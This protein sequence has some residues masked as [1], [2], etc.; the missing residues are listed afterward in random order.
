[1]SVTGA[2]TRN[3]YVASSGQTVFPYT[4]QALSGSDVTVIVNGV[5][6]EFNSQYT[7]SNV[8]LAG[9]GNVI[10]TTG[11]SSGETVSV[12]L[13][14][15]ISRTTNYQNAG[16][17][18]AS[19]VNGDFDKA[20]V[21]LNQV[22]TSIDR[23]IGLK[24]NDPTVELE[25]PLAAERAN[26]FLLFDANGN[27]GFTAVDPGPQITTDQVEY[28]NSA[29]GAVTRTVTDKLKE[30]ISVKDFGAVGDGVTDDTTA[31]Q[32]AIDYAE[33]LAINPQGTP[34]VFFPS[35]LYK[36]NT[37][38]VVEASIRGEGPVG[39]TLVWGG[40]AN[41]TMVQWEANRRKSF[42][43]FRFD[44]GD[45][46]P[47]I[48]FDAT[49][50]SESSVVPKLD[51][52]HKIYSLFFTKTAN[53]TDACHMNLPKIINFYT[54]DMRFAAAPHLVRIAQETSASSNRVFA[55]QDWTV[56]FNQLPADGV[57]SLFKVDIQGSGSLT[58]AL[59]N[60]RIETR[61]NAMGSPKAIVELHNTRKGLF[62]DGSQSFPTTTPTQTTVVLTDAPDEL[63]YRSELSITKGGVLL[64]ASKYTYD[65][66]T[67]TVEF[68]EQLA[69]QAVV[70]NWSPLTLPVEGV[71]LDMRDMG[72]QLTKYANPSDPEDTSQVSQEAVL[73][74][75]P[76]GEGDPTNV[77]SDIQLQ[78]VF[79]NGFSTFY[80]GNWNTAYSTPDSTNMSGS[81]RIKFWSNGRVDQ[82]ASQQ[83]G[84]YVRI[85]DATQFH[86][87]AANSL[88]MAGVGT[89]VAMTLDVHG[90]LNVSDNTGVTKAGFTGSTGALRVGNTAAGTSLGSVVKKM[91]VFDASGSSLGFVAVYDAIS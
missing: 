5:T 15:A 51:W 10:L 1:M 45:N 21:A 64:G 3:D 47:K 36:I 2:T 58:L 76:N 29:A 65:S 30:E 23:S 16:D 88:S 17:F 41:G 28:N 79:V 90:D 86:R 91:E 87:E 37:I 12:F 81:N 61:N 75:H 80:G 14:M 48:W 8:G 27:I 74:H 33:T 63:E 67:Q 62:P 49:W 52:G 69:S 50:K 38:S 40:A 25:L 66:S 7:V 78:N 89:D 24:D 39:C 68:E 44:S 73:I 77:T 85:G 22:Q 84:D 4:F 9:G 57:K 18:L 53:V 42:S 54:R 43:G 72:I 11:A 59:S 35:G 20:Y 83:L 70:V 19:D 71:S 13:S 56:D 46:S 34:T 60:A 32:A 55:M 6:L 26:K 31:V 82:K